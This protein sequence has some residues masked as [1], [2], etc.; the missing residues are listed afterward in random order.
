MPTADAPSSFLRSAMKFSARDSSAHV[1]ISVYLWIGSKSCDGVRLDWAAE[2][3]SF[4]SGSGVTCSLG[5]IK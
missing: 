4:E 5:Q 2:E 3:S 1:R